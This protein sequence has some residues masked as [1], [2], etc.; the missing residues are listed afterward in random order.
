MLIDRC[1]KRGE[2]T[3]VDASTLGRWMKCMVVTSN[4]VVV[5]TMGERG[6]DW[7][8]QST[9]RAIVKRGVSPLYFNALQMAETA[10]LA[11]KRSQSRGK[12]GISI[13]RGAAD[14]RAG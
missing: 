14:C 13:F 6:A 2:C 10:L 11:G 1:C 5:C 8:Q 9:I 12:A 4:V 3:L 7:C